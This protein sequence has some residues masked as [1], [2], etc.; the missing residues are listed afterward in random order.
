L[1]AKGADVRSS[2]CGV[3]DFEGEL[4]NLRATLLS[5]T[6]ASLIMGGAAH[7]ADFFAP[8]MPVPAFDWTGLYIG[9][10]VG[11][12]W[13]T[14]EWTDPFGVKGGQRETVFDGTL[15]SY[16]INGFLGGGQ[17]GY[18]WQHD[19]VVFGVEAQASW[20]DMKGS[21]LF[22]A[23]KE[24]EL[25]VSGRSKVDAL[26]S[27]AG[28]IGGSFD[29][30]MLYVKGGAAWAREKHTLDIFFLG[31]ERGDRGSS[32]DTRWGWMLGAGVEHAF[33]DSIS[34][35]LE[36]NYMDFGKKSHRFRI[37]QEDEVIGARIRQ[38]IHLV[39]A[40]INF[41]FFTPAF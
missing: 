3:F 32:S 24:G 28:R 41:R 30:T 33:T 15:G 40:G 6:A 4:M 9:A 21:D 11:G 19:W 36:Y 16:N 39:K 29:R 37:S 26:G 25:F 13:G 31:K 1:F 8:P 20:A 34:G 10:H 22:F 23:A 14:K 38:D 27:F 2:I 17:I 18:N 12:G 35:K 5:A 7:A